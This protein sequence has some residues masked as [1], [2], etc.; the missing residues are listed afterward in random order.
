MK[1]FSRLS[2]AAYGF[3]FGLAVLITF[4]LVLHFSSQM[5]GHSTG[6]VY[7]MGHHIWWFKYA[8]QHGD[9]IFWQPLSGY[10]DGFSAVSLW[11]D[12][13]QF[14]PDWLFAFIMPV[15]SAYNLTILLTMALNG[16]AMCFVM[17]NWLGN[18]ALSDDQARICTPALFAGVIYMAFPTMQGHLFGGH[19][20]LLV[21]WGAP[22]YIYGLFKLVEDSP[23]SDSNRNHRRWFMLAVLFFLVTVSGHT[24]QIFYILMPLTGLFILAR[25][26]QRDW[27]GVGQV[28]LVSL[29]GGILLLIFVLPVFRETFADNTYTGDKGYVRFSLDALAAISPSFGHPFFAQLDY[30]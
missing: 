6:D 24:L 23:D 28:L 16:W 26:A 22:L 5:I 19:A 27:R 1:P 8:L 13:L 4:P 2:L 10:P 15:A 11:A 12:P 9:N 25:L 29:V 18:D 30:P 3:F 14:F 21:A 7:E 20:G 17:W